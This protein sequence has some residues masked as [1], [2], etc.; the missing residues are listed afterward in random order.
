MIRQDMELG[1]KFWEELISYF[2]LTRQGAH[3]NGNI[4]REGHRHREQ[5]D[6]SLLTKFRGQ[7][8]R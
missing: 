4:W 2:T 8:A 3:N 7:T 6:I 5:G 1:K